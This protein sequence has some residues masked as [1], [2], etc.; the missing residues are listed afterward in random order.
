MTGSQ[1]T[2]IQGLM[3]YLYL[4][5]LCAFGNRLL[6]AQR[7]LKMLKVKVGSHFVFLALK[8]DFHNSQL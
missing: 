3:S 1:H 5:S 8:S 6:S 4:R 7:P 2:I